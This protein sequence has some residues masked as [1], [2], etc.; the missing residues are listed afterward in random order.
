MKSLILILALALIQLV[1]YPA[2][3]LEAEKTGSDGLPSLEEILDRYVKAVGGEGAVA[4]IKT[5]VFTGREIDDRPYAGPVRVTPFKAHSALSDKWVLVW[6]GDKARRREGFDGKVGWRQDAKGVS[7]EELNHRSKL[8]WLLNPQGP[9]KL[10][11]YFPG[12]KVTERSHIEGKPAYVVET[13]R[14]R[15]Y[16]SLWFDVETG[17]LVRIG[18]YWSLKDYRRVGGVLIPFRVERSRKGGSTTYVFDK[19]ENSS[20]LDDALFKKP[21]AKKEPTAEKG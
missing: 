11:Q 17:L 8:A 14:E 20:K 10:R 7:L 6:E 13:D 2:F 21:E 19:V 5:R 18:Y 12:M 4:K 1:A 15:A 3:S 16:Y 9:L